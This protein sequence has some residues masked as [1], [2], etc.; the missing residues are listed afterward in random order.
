MQERPGAAAEGLD[1]GG[2]VFGY[3]CCCCRGGR[4]FEELGLGGEGGEGVA[5]SAAAGEEEYVSLYVE[6][7]LGVNLR[8]PVLSEDDTFGVLLW[9]LGAGAGAANGAI[10]RGRARRLRF[11]CVVCHVGLR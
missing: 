8:L 10:D 7:G 2:A 4:G 11:C 5:G 1:V 6:A 9:R 3:C